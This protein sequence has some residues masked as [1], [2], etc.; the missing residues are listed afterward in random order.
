MGQKGSELIILPKNNLFIKTSY[1]LHPRAS[2]GFRLTWR[3]NLQVGIKRNPLILNRHKNQKPR[4]QLRETG[5]LELNIFLHKKDKEFNSDY[6][7]NV[8][9]SVPPEGRPVIWY[10][11]VQSRFAVAA[12]V[13]DNG[14][15]IKLPKPVAY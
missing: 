1:L 9:E 5:F 2:H 7:D 14:D 15:Q 11:L 8:N 12:V 10:P 3:L 13:V 6:L 4:S